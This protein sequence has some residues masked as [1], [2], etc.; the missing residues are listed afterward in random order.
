MAKPEEVIEQLDVRTVAVSPL[1]YNVKIED[2]E[3]L[4]GQSPK[5]MLSR[6]LI[7]TNAHQIC[8]VI[9]I[10]VLFMFFT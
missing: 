7:Y 1:P 8:L 9:C 3:S 2:V 4:F 5:V 10:V 6:G